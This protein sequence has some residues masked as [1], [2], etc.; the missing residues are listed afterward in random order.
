[1]R[2]ILFLFLGCTVVWAQL[3][4]TLK[5]SWNY[6]K[7]NKIAVNGRPLADK[8]ILDISVGSI[9]KELTYSESV[10]YVLFRA[11]IQDDKETFD[12]VWLWSLQNL[13]R[14]N[15]PRVFN[16]ETRRWQ[17]VPP[18]LKDYLFAWRYTPNIRNTNMGGVIYVA[19]EDRALHGWRD[20]LTVASDGDQ[21]I[22]GALIMAN[23]R[24]GSSLGEYDYLGYAQKIVA[25]IW[26]KCVLNLNSELIENFQSGL[27]WFEY[28]GQG[29]LA[30]YIDTEKENSYLA[31]E[32]FGCNYYGVGKSLN[33]MSFKNKRGLSFKTKENSGVNIILEDNFGKKINFRRNY[34][35]SSD[36]RKGRSNI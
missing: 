23:K 9:A 36:W 33:E 7:T 35:Y 19:D 6:Y 13:M 28:K 1:M 14:K 27:T 3:D 17:E 2:L 8:D 18:Y 26:D 31:C 12:K 4:T 16:W 20:G 15:I 21:L 30:K 25:N 5:N 22:A 10:S 32:A 11:V 29:S 34:P 24:W